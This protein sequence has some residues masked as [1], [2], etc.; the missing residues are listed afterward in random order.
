MRQSGQQQGRIGKIFIYFGQGVKN[1]LGGVLTEQ[2]IR[3][4][5]RNPTKKEEQNVL[6]KEFFFLNRNQRQHVEAEFQIYIFWEPCTTIRAG[7]IIKL[8]SFMS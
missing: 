3:F 4:S 8:S 7:L 5:L 2:E 6:L 1:W